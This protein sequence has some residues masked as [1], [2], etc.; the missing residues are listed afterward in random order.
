MGQNETSPAQTEI[1][2]KGALLFADQLNG[3]RLLQTVVMNRQYS[4]EVPK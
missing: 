2:Q 1:G 3:P 4:S